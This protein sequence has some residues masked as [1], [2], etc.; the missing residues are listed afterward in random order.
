MDFLSDDD[1]DQSEGLRINKK[2]AQRFEKQ[3][4]IDELKRSKSL[5]DLD[6]DDEDDSD[7]ESEDDDAELLSHDL[8]LN[9]LNTINS[10]RKKDPVVYDKQKIWFKRD[11][12]EDE[13]ENDEVDQ[14]SSKKKT[15]KD[16]V[17][18]QLLSNTSVDNDDKFVESENLQ[19]TL[20]TNKLAYDK[21]QISLRK[22]FLESIN[23]ENDLDSDEILTEKVKDPD[24][25]RTEILEIEKALEEMQTLGKD[26]SSNSNV[27]DEVDQFLADY[28]GKQKWKDDNGLKLNHIGDESLESNYI[29]IENDDDDESEVEEADAFE[30]K[31]NFRFEELEDA[32]GLKD[33]QVLGH[34]RSVSTSLRRVDDKRKIQR[35]LQKERKEREKRQKEAEIRRL[36]NLKRQEVMK[37][38]FDLLFQLLTLF[39]C[40]CKKG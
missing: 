23:N 5:L 15:Y 37:S 33:I 13:N 29:D 31:Y 8:E 3:K 11:V 20:T 38:L 19:H 12:S 14:S 34:S 2:F 21:E 40:S 27:V 16:I 7:D 26:S 28:I 30:S 25:V 18:E 10:I 22:K 24:Q 36:K 6:E 35:Q 39:L 4:R 17:R 32:E 9:I 1:Q